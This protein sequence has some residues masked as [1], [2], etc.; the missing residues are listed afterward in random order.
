[1]TSTYGTINYTERFWLIQGEPFVRARLKRVFPRVPHHAAKHICISVTPENT[2]ELAWFIDRYPMDVD[3]RDIMDRLA[4]H[5]RDSE[6]RLADLMAGHVTP[7]EIKLA[8]PAREYQ[9]FAAQMLELRGGFL[10]ADDLGLGKTVSA[11][12][13]TILEQP[14]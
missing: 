5:H 14:Q 8:K 4:D 6:T 7:F 2:R 11:T 1:M 12:E 9:A 13:I 3:R 10:L